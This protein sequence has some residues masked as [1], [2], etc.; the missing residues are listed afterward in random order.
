MPRKPVSEFEQPGAPDPAS[1]P[2]AD[3]NAGFEAPGAAAAMSAE[4]AEAEAESYLAAVDSQLLS[5]KAELEKMLSQGAGDAMSLQTQEVMDANIV[6]VGIGIGD[7]SSM[8]AGCAPGDPLLEVYTIEPESSRETRARLAA[9]AGISAL[10][11]SD[12]PM[13]AVHTG[14]IDAFAHRMRL[15][16][17]PGGISVGHRAIT[18]GTLGCLVRGTTAPRI[19]RLMILSNNH[20]L[21]N[22]NAG[23]IGD[24]ILQPGPFD[25]G[26]LPADQVAVLERFIPISF[27][28]GAANSVDCATGWAW[29]D[30][31]RR[32]L[33][34]LSG[35]APAFFRV[36]TV[37]VAAVP[38]MPAGKSGRTTQLTRG[39]VTAVGVTINVNYG[40]GRVARFVNQ[41][42]LRAASGDFSQGGD[43]G[44]LIWTWDARRAPVGLLFAGGGGT[45]FANRIGNVLAA[46]DVQ[47]FT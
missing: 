27:A 1:R 42:A 9:V 6:G 33:M 25:G 18:A 39:S 43:S 40:G 47:L 41:I 23:A 4:A 14:I 21:A 13:H 35:G 24:A 17:A 44:S 3:E 29:P 30:R 22:S 31:V 2:G 11:S 12:F 32:E 34:F 7:A 8:G 5:V 37:P 36:G 38:G 45:T 10:A 16:P 26:T 28:A 20:V 19:N 15:R 46:L